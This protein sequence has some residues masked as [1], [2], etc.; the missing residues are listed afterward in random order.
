VETPVPPVLGKETAAE[1]A[2]IRS[3][4]L[5]HLNSQLSGSAVKAHGDWL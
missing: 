4:S 3:S 5:R 1:L 2:S